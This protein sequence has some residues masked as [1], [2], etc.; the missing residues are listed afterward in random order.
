MRIAST[1]S[2]AGEALLALLAN[3]DADHDL[4][5]QALNPGD[6]EELA[7]LAGRT[8]SAPQL[9]EYLA[10]MAETSVPA[11]LMHQLAEAARTHSLASL[12]QAQGLVAAVRILEHAGL[13]VLA[14][15]G[16]SLA[17]R[18][19]PKPQ[20]RPLRDI[21]LLL[22]IDQVEEG[23]RVLLAHDGYRRAKWAVPH[24]VEHG[25]QM[26]EI[27]D[28]QRGMV[29]ELHHGLNARNWNESD[30]LLEQMWAE[31]EQMEL[32][33]QAIAV[34]SA[35]A[36]LL[37]LI[38][39]TTLHHAFANGPLVLSDLHYLGRAHRIDWDRIA[40]RAEQLNLGRSLDLIA[41]LARAYG[42]C[43]V[44][45]GLES[46]EQERVTIAAAALLDD[47]ETHRQHELLRRQ[48]QRDGG[49]ASASGAIKRMLRPNPHE[50]ARLSGHPPTSV[51]RWLGY[52]AWLAEKGGRY[53]RSAS[54]PA[55]Q[56]ANAERIALVDWLGGS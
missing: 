37:H 42:A 3:P 12:S 19:Y 32:F 8:R 9:H 6:W 23:E 40:A 24:G 53:R 36:N 31:A 35:A 5:L 50:L 17:F 29:I 49:G 22:P 2:D 26:P 7:A 1:I 48:A 15:K 38:E 55:L 39:H 21:D 54:D 14:L 51:L 46:V 30:L 41:A 25:H 47:E 11:A 4:R 52:L 28:R 43:W 45:D 33:G 18:D 27:V 56:A 13:K 34:P 16:A 10:R 20:L 44:P